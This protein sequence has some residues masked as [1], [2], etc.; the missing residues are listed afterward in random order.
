MKRLLWISSLVAVAAVALVVARRPAAAHH[1]SAPFYDDTQRVEAVGTVS[2]FI[3]RNPHSL[4]FV[5]GRTEAGEAVEWEIEMSAAVS[6]R[7]S[8]WTPETIKAGDPIKAVGQ[9]SRAP[10]TYGM[11]CA[12]LTR[13]DGSPIRP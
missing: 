10:G 4:L 8:G 5:D 12:Q 2:R 6:M 11:C 9:P 3:F 13:P 1:S 7:R